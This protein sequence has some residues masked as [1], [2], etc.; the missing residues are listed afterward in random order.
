MNK[1]GILTKR[2]DDYFAEMTKSDEHMKRVR[3]T[4]LSK[5]AEVERREKVRKLREMKKMGKQIQMEAEKKKQESKRKLK[6]SIKKFKKGEKED[7]QIELEDD[8]SGNKRLKRE[9]E[10][11][12][13]AEN[14]FKRAA[15]GKGA[16]GKNGD[17]KRSK[18]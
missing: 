18:K 13:D 6:E 10:N 16:N 8:Y 11:A 9:R 15:N 14:G 12:G 7:L 1:L 2:P 17:N 3:E 4:L 5:H